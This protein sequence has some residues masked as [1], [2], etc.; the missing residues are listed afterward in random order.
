MDPK[1]KDDKKEII[2][3][4]THE[5]LSKFIRV[6]V[7]SINPSSEITESASIKVNINDNF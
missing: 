1:A 7:K 2:E 5:N 6:N 4:I 3:K